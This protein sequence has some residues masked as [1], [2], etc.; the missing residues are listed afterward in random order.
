MRPA[1]RATADY[2]LPVYFNP[3]ERTVLRDVARARGLRGGT[4]LKL[5]LRDEHRRL[6]LS[7]DG[8]APG[9]P[10]RPLQDDSAH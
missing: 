10:P 4:L 6:G 8:H 3:E 7:K 2:C 1:P 5:L 9:F